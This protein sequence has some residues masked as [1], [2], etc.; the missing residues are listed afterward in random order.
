MIVAFSPDGRWLVSGT[1]KEFRFW[2]VESGE[3]GLRISREGH[4]SCPG[5]LAFSRDGTLLAVQQSRSLVK[6]FDPRTGAELAS[7]AAPDFGNSAPSLCF[8][9]DGSQLVMGDSRSQVHVWD[10]RRTRAH[11]A[12]MRLDWDLLPYPPSGPDA[13]GGRLHGTVVTDARKIRSF[14]GLSKRDNG[15]ALS[16]DGRYGLSV[17][18]DGVLRYGAWRRGRKS[19]GSSATPV[20]LCAWPFRGMAAAPSPAGKI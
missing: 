10:V 14:S 4:E 17:S 7:L 5:Q 13:A 16:P 15:M 11:L 6:L 20:G 1:D 9:A 12:S 8:N 3:P 18:P 2:R 19:A